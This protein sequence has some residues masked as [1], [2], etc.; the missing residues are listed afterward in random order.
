M[1]TLHWLA[2]SH[3]RTT[4]DAGSELSE[5]VLFPA[6]PT[7]SRG[8]ED[9]RLVRFTHDDGRVVYYGTYTAFDGHQ[10]LPQL[11]ET[12]DF[13][14][15]DVSMLS[16]R[17]A[18]NKGL[19]LFPRKLGGRFVALGRQDNVNNFLM[20]SDDLRVWNEIE[21]IQ[22]PEQPWELMQLGNCGSP[23]ETEAGWLV[24]THGVGPMRR[25]SLGALLLDHDDPV[26]V[27]GHLNEPLLAP[28]SAEREGYVPNVVYSCGSMIHGD[29]LVLPYGFADVGAGLA[30]IPLDGIAH[31]PDGVT[32]HPSDG[33]RRTSRSACWNVERAARVDSAPWFSFTPASCRPS[34][35]PPVA[36]S[37]MTAPA[38]LSPSNHRAAA[39]RPA[40]QAAS[41]ETA[42]AR[43][44]ASAMA[45]TSIG[46]WSNPG[47]WSPG[48]AAAA[49]RGRQVPAAGLPIEQP[50]QQRRDRRRPGR[51]GPGGGP[52]PAGPRAARRW[53]R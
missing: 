39:S 9:V 23:L 24:I 41:P 44:Q 46:C 37:H 25:Y 38:S 1:R 15:F 45:A 12:T 27:I 31:P 5:R 7:E 2:A 16:G 34:K 42:K 36:G 11:L 53:R 51:P 40:S 43:L 18:H 14:S 22:E 32:A 4:F 3:Y 48:P 8:M 28:I 47:R 35:P 49:G 13:V 21:R 30:T 6:G 52:P 17:F 29:Q 10:I 26:R 50:P 20:T 33:V 19:A